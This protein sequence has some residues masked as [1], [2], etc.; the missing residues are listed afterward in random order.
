[1]LV[2]LVL[3]LITLPNGTGAKLRQRSAAATESSPRELSHVRL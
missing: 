1:M 3:L 2:E